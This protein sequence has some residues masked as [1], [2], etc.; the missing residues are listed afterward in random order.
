MTDLTPDQIWWTAQE[1][2]DAGLPDIPATRKGVEK[3]VVRISLRA[4]PDYARKR[5]G[6]GGGW[7]YHWKALPVRAQRALLA[8]AS[9]PAPAAPAVD[10]DT[11]WA[12]FEGLPEAAQDKARVRLRIIQSVDALEDQLGR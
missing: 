9:A 5:A 6:R 3:W 4:H 10:R 11:A 1:L 12:W 2:A 7:E 8:K